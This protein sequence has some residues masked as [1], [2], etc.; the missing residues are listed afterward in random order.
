MLDYLSGSLVKRLPTAVVLDVG[1]VGFSLSVS[2]TTSIALEALGIGQQVKLFVIVSVGS[3]DL[4]VRLFGFFEEQERSLFQLL[5]SVKGVGPGLAIRILSGVSPSELL[6]ALRNQDGAR[7]RKIKGVGKKSAERILFDLKDRISSLDFSQV[8]LAGGTLEPP[9]VGEALLAMS[10]LGY[11]T[12]QARRAVDKAL[13]KL[14][15]GLS[16]EQ[17]VRGALQEVS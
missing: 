3:N 10:A 1:G 9:V 8:E 13:K 14:G 12:R 5:T 4:Q 11:D 16:P 2:V 15:E 7:L 6:E 17:L